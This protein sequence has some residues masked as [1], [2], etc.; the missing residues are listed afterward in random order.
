[1]VTLRKAVAIVL[2]IDFIGNYNKIRLL[3]TIRMRKQAGTIPQD[4]ILML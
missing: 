2:G 3:E 1:M 4:C